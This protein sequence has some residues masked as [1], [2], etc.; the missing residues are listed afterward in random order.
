MTA[1]TTTATIDRHIAQSAFHSAMRANGGFW[2]GY[3]ASPNG[4]SRSANMSAARKLA[5]QL[6]G[7]GFLAGT[8]RTLASSDGLCLDIFYAA[9]K[10]G[11]CAFTGMPMCSCNLAASWHA[12]GLCIDCEQRRVHAEKLARAETEAAEA[13]MLEP[14]NSPDLPRLRAE[15]VKAMAL[16]EAAERGERP[17]NLG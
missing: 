15:H 13:C 11:V 17:Y 10:A 5:T 3:E 7:K 9:R 14:L 4:E 2:Q 16:A 6:F 8:G 12:N 1:T